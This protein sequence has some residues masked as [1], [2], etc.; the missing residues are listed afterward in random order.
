MTLE[1]AVSVYLRLLQESSKPT[2]FGESSNPKNDDEGRD[3]N[4]TNENETRDANEFIAFLLWY[5][6]LVMCCIIPT[7][8]A[9]RRRRQI[10]ARIVEQQQQSN[11]WQAAN[12][13]SVAGLR[14]DRFYGGAQDNEQIQA[15]R[16]AHLE[17]E[18]KLTTMV[19]LGLSFVRLLVSQSIYRILVL[20]FV[21]DTDRCLLT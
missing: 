1:A 16:T 10:E 2:G 15:H 8:C 18:L 9:Y 3:E 13:S 6:F 19:S 20:W 5:I 7:C 17:K 11:R 14:Q 4:E 12:R 21:K